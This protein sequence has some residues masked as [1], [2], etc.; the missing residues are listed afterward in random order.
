MVEYLRRFR[1][2]SGLG[3]EQMGGLLGLSGN[4][5]QRLVAGEELPGS[6]GR[7]VQLL[8]RCPVG[9]LDGLI[10]GLLRTAESSDLELRRI[11][12]LG[13]FV[14]TRLLLQS[15]GV[16]REQSV[17]EIL[18]IP[19]ST[20]CPAREWVYWA[21]SERADADETLRLARDHKF[22]CRPL[23]ASNGR[24]PAYL[25]ALNVDDSVL[26]CHDGV[27]SAWFMLKRGRMEDGRANV[28]TLPPTFR[29]ISRG[30]PLGQR[31]ARSGY[32]DQDGERNPR[33]DAWFSGLS[34]KH[35]ESKTVSDPAPRDPGVTDAMTPYRP[36]R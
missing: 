5:F 33:P 2:A 20:P 30:D 9:Q 25:A 11:R 22:I 1:W 27:P 26:L 32:P 15:P 13:E 17:S 36:L 6:V 16:S 23:R 18:P 7:I 4:H 29:F 8:L 31:L 24:I 12:N 14:T 3:A 28:G 21:T 10:D 19:S 34:V 35:I